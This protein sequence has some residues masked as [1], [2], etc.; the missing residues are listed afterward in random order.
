MGY[1]NSIEQSTNKVSKNWLPILP[2][3]RKEL[4]LIREKK[5]PDDITTYEYKTLNDAKK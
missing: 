2:I 5:L 3:I 4:N 1:L